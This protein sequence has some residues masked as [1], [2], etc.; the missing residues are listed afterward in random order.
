MHIG[1]KAVVHALK[2]QTI[3][4]A[5]MHVLRRCFLLATEY[6]LDLEARWTSTKENA[7]ADGLL[8]SEYYRLADLVPQLL[9]PA[10]SVPLCVF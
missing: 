1:N 2:N 5:S 10:S 6:G 8:M 4:G 7:L 9:Q 3:C